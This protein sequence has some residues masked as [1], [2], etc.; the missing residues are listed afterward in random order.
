MKQWRSKAMQEDSDER[1]RSFQEAGL[2]YGMFIK[3]KER[4]VRS[5]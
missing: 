5:G 1:A 3:R 2:F 4:M